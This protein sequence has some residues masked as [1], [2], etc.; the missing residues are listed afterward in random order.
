MSLRRCL[1]EQREPSH[2]TVSTSS[3]P[4]P[5]DQLHQLPAPLPL[6]EQLPEQLP[7]VRATEHL[8]AVRVLSHPTAQRFSPPPCPLLSLLKLRR[9][10]AVPRRPSDAVAAAALHSQPPPHQLASRRPREP[11]RD[12]SDAAAAASRPSARPT[13]QQ[14]VRAPLPTR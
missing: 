4:L 8:P 7:V 12:P 10:Y 3:A 6:P 9:S 5:L 13:P 14:T 2:A 1:C 11:P